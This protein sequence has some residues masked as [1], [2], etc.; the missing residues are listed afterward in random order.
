MKITILRYLLFFSF[1]IFLVPMSMVGQ[2]ESYRGYRVH[3][4]QL[5]VVKES[6]QTFEIAYQAVNTGRQDLQFGQSQEKELTQLLVSFDPDFDKNKIL[7]KYRTQ[8]I[9]ALKNADYAIVAGKIGPKKVMEVAMN[10]V[11]TNV[12]EP[13]VEPVLDDTTEPVTTTA[14]SANNATDNSSPTMSSAAVPSD[15]Y[16]NPANCPDLRIESIRVLKK[17]RRSVTIEYTIKNIGKAPANLIGKE[18]NINDNV[19]VKAYM[20]SSE[21][22]NKGALVIGGG[23]VGNRDKNDGMLL[24]DETHVST[25]KL[26]IY[27]MTKFTPMVILEL[28]TFEQVKE[29]NETNNKNH[30]KVR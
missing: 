30:V 27:N 22:L 5:K 10:E 2:T 3:L 12:E 1:M 13:M 29:C 23:Y 26:D 14:P 6:S 8:I 7:S 18:K 21:K 25:I 28:D 20:T 11:V 16:Y 24:P 17:N 15:D 4:T 9:A 19:A